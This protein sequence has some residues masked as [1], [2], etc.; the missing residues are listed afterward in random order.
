MQFVVDTLK[1]TNYN[2]SARTVQL[3]CSSVAFTSIKYF[4]YNTDSANRAKVGYMPWVYALVKRN[5]QNEMMLQ[6]SKTLHN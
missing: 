4:L 2:L 3:P 1:V 6:F 5:V